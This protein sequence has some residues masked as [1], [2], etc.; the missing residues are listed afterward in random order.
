[1]LNYNT[2]QGST[3]FIVLNLTL[4]LD[5]YGHADSRSA[6]SFCLSRQVFEILAFTFLSSF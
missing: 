5:Q 4:D 2:G 1:M 3:V 6:F